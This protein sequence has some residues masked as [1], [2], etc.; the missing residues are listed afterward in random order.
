MK[1][2]YLTFGNWSRILFPVF[3]FLT[4]AHAATPAMGQDPAGV[5]PDAIVV[6]VRDGA[7]RVRVRVFN[8]AAGGWETFAMA[9]LGGRAG[10]VKMRLPKDVPLGEI[11]V[12]VS[13]TDDF[14]HTYFT[15]RNDFLEAVPEGQTGSYYR[16]AAVEPATLDVVNDVAAEGEKREA[17]IVESDIWKIRGPALYYFNQMRGLQ[18][19]DLSDPAR[20]RLRWS[21]RMPAVGEQLYVPGD[22]EVI[23]LTNPGWGREAEVVFAALT[24]SGPMIGKRVP[25]PGRIAGSRMVGGMLY[26]VS[27]SYESVLV[28]HPDGG[29]WEPRWDTVVTSINSEGIAVSSLTIPGGACA[30]TVTATSTHL[31]AAV[32]NTGQWHSSTVHVID[33]SDPAKE[34]EVEDAI[35]LDGYIADKFKMQLKDGILTC[36]SRVNRD[37]HGNWI[38]ITR[39]ETFDLNP[40]SIPEDPVDYVRLG[41]LDLG[42]NEM[43]HATRFAGDLVYIVTFFRI[44]PL[45]IVD[46]SDPGEPKIASEIEIPGWSTYLEPAGDNLAAVGVEDCRVTVSLF[47]VADPHNP[48]LASRVY[49]SEE[50]TCSWSEANYDEKAVSILP[51]EGLILVP[52]QTRDVKTGRN[53]SAVQ[54]VD[55]AEGRLVLRGVIGHAFTPRRAAA[56]GG[57]LVSISGRELLVVDAADRD[58]PEVVAEAEIAWAADRVFVT[59][60]Y[61][62]QI[63]NGQYWDGTEAALRVTP[64]YKAPFAFIEPADKLLAH[65]KL[66]PGRIVG[67]VLKDGYLYVARQENEYNYYYLEKTDDN[68]KEPVLTAT[69]IDV[70][71]PLKPAVL[72]RAGMPRQALYWNAGL[73]AHWL[74]TGAGLET[75]IWTSKPSRNYWLD[76]GLRGGAVPELDGALA[77]VR[78]MPAPC[79]YSPGMQVYA[80][81]V[82]DK[83]APKLL[84]AENIQPEG[85]WDYSPAVL[86]EG[87]L[88]FSCKRS[89]WEIWAGDAKIDE[90]STYPDPGLWPPDEES[91]NIYVSGYFLRAADYRDPAKPVLRKPLSLP[92][93]LVSVLAKDEDAAI[94]FTSLDRGYYDDGANRYIYHS[95]VQASAYDGVG[96]YLADEIE[97]GQWAAYGPLTAQGSFIYKAIPGRSPDPAVSAAFEPQI[98]PVKWTEKGKL[99]KLEPVASQENVNELAVRDGLLLAKSYEELKVFGLADPGVPEERV[100]HS[101]PSNLWI[102]LENSEILNRRG[103][104]LAAGLY[105]VEYLALL[106]EPPPPQAVDLGAEAGALA[107]PVVA[108]AMRAGDFPEWT[109]VP[110]DEISL[111]RL[112]DPAK[113]GVLVNL[114]WIFQPEGFTEFDAGACDMGDGWNF[115]KWFGCYSERAWPWL[116]HTEHG[117]IYPYGGAASGFWY[118]DKALG[119]IWTKAAC[120]P[121]LYSVGEE[122]WLWFNRGNA[123]P[124][125]FYNYTTNAWEFY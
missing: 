10:K 72:G 35:P 41:K 58:H 88:Y 96:L 5:D 30:S 107:V 4:A 51:G 15:G 92:G 66:G 100:S 125:W 12:E 27:E 81:D 112:D 105:G 63:G 116:Y 78:L 40:L 102:S 49:L 48:S 14:P 46:I 17:E 124:R 25:V 86:A 56:L 19:F 13:R 80:L 120:Y 71:D 79:W 76:W 2:A 83:T 47:D 37:E 84:S 59:G 121:F 98:L 118:W 113:V 32:R 61:L 99:E 52:Y 33:I 68:Y 57:R 8:R 38:N 109:E 111:L 28:E 69:V 20:P 44:D 64:A 110:E 104:W 94:L 9:H 90:S 114:N 73:E 43:L 115:A 77:D 101:L 54:L 22:D 1:L 3:A 50:G 7:R 6:E 60:D 16:Y 39:L 106:P 70:Q 26:V 108:P 18:V 36:I 67:A 62:L 82:T 95:A 31:M 103:I 23:L 45:W 123:S 93:K 89:W 29:I 122:G 91:E 119:W 75:L 117:W 53:V 74:D 42:E 55:M 87:I 24:K 34:L 65:L 21:L 11:K 97:L 85:T